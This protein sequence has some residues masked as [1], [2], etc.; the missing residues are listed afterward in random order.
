MRFLWT[1]SSGRPSASKVWKNI[2]YGVAT[3]VVIRNAN[4]IAW[5]LLL[6]YLGVVGGSELATRVI[7][8]KFPS[9]PVK[10]EGDEK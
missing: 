1:T 3:F 9:P 7:E 4:T 6:V 5:D 8:S 2:A 10:K